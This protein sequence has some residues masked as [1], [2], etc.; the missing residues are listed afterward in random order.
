VFNAKVTFNEG[1]GKF[2]FNSFGGETGS[3]DIPYNK[4]TDNMRFSKLFDSVTTF[5]RTGKSI[6]STDEADIKLG[7]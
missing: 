1:S 5:G 6:R 2:G 4:I 7:G 3:I